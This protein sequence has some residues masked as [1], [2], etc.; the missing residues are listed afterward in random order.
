M[1][2]REI[3]IRVHTLTAVRGAVSNTNGDL[4]HHPTSL[5][6]DLAGRQIGVE[7]ALVVLRVPNELLVVD[8]LVDQAEVDTNGQGVVRL[9]LRHVVRASDARL[10]TVHDPG[11]V[12]VVQVGTE[13]VPLL[14]RHIIGERC[15]D[16]AAGKAAPLASHGCVHPEISVLVHACQRGIQD[17]GRGIVLGELPVLGL[18]A[19]RTDHGGQ[20]KGEVLVGFHVAHVLVHRTSVTLPDRSCSTPSTDLAITVYTYT[21]L[22][23][24]FPSWVPSHPASGSVVSKIISPQLL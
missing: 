13:S 17:H 21:P 2:Q 9:A 22:I 11:H 19:C 6:H 7:V 16:E 8:L 23:S 15:G 12:V 10:E 4:R 20:H 5:L 1:E 18:H 24:G 3:A 14:D